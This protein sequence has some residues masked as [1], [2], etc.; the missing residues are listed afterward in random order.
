MDSVRER[1]EVLRKSVLAELKKLSNEQRALESS[2]L[3]EKLVK[4][5]TSKCPKGSIIA[6]FAGLK[7]EPDLLELHQLLPDYKLAYPRCGS[8]RSLHFH[9]VTDPTSELQRGYYGIREPENYNDTLISEDSIALFIVPAVAYT[10][11]GLRLGKGGGYYD[12]VL[13]SISADTPLLGVGF[14]IQLKDS[15]PV[16]SHDIPMHHI[17]LP[18]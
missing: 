7:Y 4:W 10:E 9:I 6:T 15:L 11:D 5:I 13:D 2:K 14:S 17:I 16:E 1:K 12:R 8:D 18:M 3:R